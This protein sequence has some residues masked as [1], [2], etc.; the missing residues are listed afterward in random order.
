[1]KKIYFTIIMIAILTGC[2]HWDIHQQKQTNKYLGKH[3]DK[4]YDEYGAPIA[5]APMETGG[6]FIEFRTF[7]SGFECSASV[8]TDK[9]GIV[10][11]IATGGQNG[12]IAGKY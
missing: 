5:I 3:Y 7:N 8:K 4:L 6:K 10:T 1:M 12:C 9:N 2:A 11:S